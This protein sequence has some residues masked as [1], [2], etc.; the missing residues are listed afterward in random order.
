MALVN[1]VAVNSLPFCLSV[2]CLP[3]LLFPLSAPSCS[4]LPPSLSESVCLSLLGI[5]AAII[6][7]PWRQLCHICTSP[8]CVSC[9]TPSPQAWGCSAETSPCRS[10]LEHKGFSGQSPGLQLVELGLALETSFRSLCDGGLPTVS[11]V[12]REG[13]LWV[14]GTLGGPVRGVCVCGVGLGIT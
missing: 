8:S 6:H 11:A 9:S 10:C 12:G 5:C 4:R 2:L 1:A 3:R 7:A 13:S 14:G